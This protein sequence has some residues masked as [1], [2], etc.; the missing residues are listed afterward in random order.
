MRSQLLQSE[1][2]TLLL[3]VEVEDNHVDLLVELH[4][5]VWIV[6]A[7]PREVSDVD[8]SV[9]TAEVNKHTV[10]SDVLDSTLENLTL[11]QLRDNL[12]LLSLN[13]LFDKSL[14]RNDYIAEL[15]VD[16]HNLEL[17]SLVNK[18]VVVAYRMNVNLA[19]GQESLDTEYVNN[20]T[21]LSAALD[22]ALDYLLVFEGGVHAIPA[23]AEASL[24]VREDELSLAV[25]LVFYVNLH[26]VAH[27][28][29]GVIAE[30]A[31]LDD[32]VAL[33][34]DVYDNLLFVH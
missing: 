16:L 23:L 6:H 14:V 5:L 34:A 4:H 22:E 7:S 32:T 33:V 21:T 12:A 30:F 9:N 15:L 17:H 1:S 31:S 13:L 29:V 3:V 20:H 24:L 28:E 10:R 25:F 19:T 26:L 8:E 11:L 27:L 2:D 18:L